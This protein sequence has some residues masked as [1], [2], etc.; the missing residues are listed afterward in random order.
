MLFIGRQSQMSTTAMKCA[1]EC[2]L[3]KC[4]ANEIGR[5]V[6]KNLRESEKNWWIKI[7]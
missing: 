7:V 2:Q 1:Q 5:D 3:I 6:F 4:V